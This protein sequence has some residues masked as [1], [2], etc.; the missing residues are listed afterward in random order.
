MVLP[1]L[2]PILGALQPANAFPT[3][4]SLFNVVAPVED[5]E[6]GE[7]PGSPEFW[8]KLIV[9]IILVLAGGVFAGYAA[10]D[11]PLCTRAH[12]APQTYPRSYGLG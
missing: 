6:P 8:Y 4:L 1:L 2:L 5:D 12:S 3:L 9:A 11:L 10:I 7:P